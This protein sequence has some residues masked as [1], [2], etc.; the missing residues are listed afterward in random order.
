[1]THHDALW[2]AIAVIARNNSKSAS[3]LARAC[4]LDATTFNP[5]KKYT[6]Y[7]QARWISTETLAKVLIS[8]NTS[9]M[10]F[11]EIFQKFLDMPE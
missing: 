9:P 5:S 6:V 8:T 1:M 7:G 4:H 2:A 10:Q 3:G 11:A